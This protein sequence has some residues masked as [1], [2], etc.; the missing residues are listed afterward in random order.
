MLQG[1]LKGYERAHPRCERDHSSSVARA[2]EDLFVGR[3][4]EGPVGLKRGAMAPVG[5]LY[6]VAHHA[7]AWIMTFLYV[8]DVVRHFCRLDRF[9]DFF[10]Q[11]PCILATSFVTFVD[12]TDLDCTETE[13]VTISYQ[14]PV[15]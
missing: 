2:I 8:D 15:S 12:W 4:P 1:P 3:W 9:R 11:T 13:L 5:P 14:T 7:N 10:F 6:F